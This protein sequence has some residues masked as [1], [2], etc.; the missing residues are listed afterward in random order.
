MDVDEIHG[1][2]GGHDYEKVIEVRVSKSDVVLAMIGTRWLGAFDENGCRRLDLPGDLLR[3]ELV[4]GMTVSHR[5][6]PILV[7]GALPLRAD[8]LPEDLKALAVCQAIELTHKRF[9]SD[10]EKIVEAVKRRLEDAE[11][12]RSPTKRTWDRESFMQAAKTSRGASLETRFTKILDWAK[13]SYSLRWGNGAK[14]G[15]FQV[16]PRGSG[17]T[18]LYFDSTGTCYVYLKGLEKQAFSI[19][20][21]L[22]I[23][24]LQLITPIII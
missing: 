5:V 17:S 3:R 13:A 21:G 20:E 19:M 6:I 23:I 4:A 24:L 9:E 18:A 22:E 7:G 12:A 1:I 16:M 2:P 15:S 14:Y 10:T 11:A 8:Q